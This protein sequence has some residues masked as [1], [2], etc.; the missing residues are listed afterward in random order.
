MC[1]C[2]LNTSVGFLCGFWI[3]HYDTVNETRGLGGHA[4]HL[5]LPWCLR[6]PL[7]LRAAQRPVGTE[8]RQR[9]EGS[10]GPSCLSPLAAV[11]THPYIHC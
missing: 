11:T 8:M 9:T 1:A 4:P 3:T 6:E 10:A 7:G 2:N 5:Q